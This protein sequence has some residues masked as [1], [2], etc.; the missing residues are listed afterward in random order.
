MPSSVLPQSAL[1]LPQRGCEV[2]QVQGVSRYGSPPATFQGL[3][4]V[5]IHRFRDG[6]QGVIPEIAVSLPRVLPAESLL[7][8]LAFVSELDDGLCV[9]VECGDR[10]PHAAGKRRPGQ[11]EKK[12]LIKMICFKFFHEKWGNHLG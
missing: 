6:V 8:S 4:G 5:N 12:K 2:S 7:E 1:V 3:I 10:C 11:A 9:G